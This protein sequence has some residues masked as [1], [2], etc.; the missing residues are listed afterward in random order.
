MARPELSLDDLRRWEDQGA[1]WRAIEVSDE[2]VVL[3]LCTCT[4]EPV[5]RLEG[6][7]RDLIEYVR[8]TIGAQA[9]RT[10]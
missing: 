5:D 3:E 8:G 7:G 9:G 2:R 4:N 1:L 6:H 10:T